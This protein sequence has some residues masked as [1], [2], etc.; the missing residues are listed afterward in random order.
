[1]GNRKDAQKKK[2]KAEQ[3]RRQAERLRRPDMV[4]VPPPAEASFLE[5]RPQPAEGEPAE[6]VAIFDAKVRGTLPADLQT[7]A[8]LVC[9]AL[10]LVAEGHLQI[11]VDR[12]TCIGR[13]SPFSEWRLFVRGLGT[14]QQGDLARARDAWSRLDPGRRPARIAQVLGDAWQDVHQAST[15]ASPAAT[16]AAVPDPATAARG[17]LGRASIWDAAQQIVTMGRRNSSTSFSASQVA[18]TIRRV[19]QV[20][21]LDPDFAAAFAAACRQLA[22]LQ[23]DHE[24]FT[25]LARGTGGPADDPQCHRATFLYLLKFVGGAQQTLIACRQHVD[26]QLPSMRFLPKELRQA[27][28]SEMLRQLASQ[29]SGDSGSESLEKVE[30]TARK[31]VE[32]LLEESIERCPA[33]RSAHSARLAVLKSRA[34]EQGSGQRAA[35]KQ[36]R[37]AQI[38]YAERFPEDHEQL[39]TVIE[40][41]IGEQQF[42]RAEPFVQEL[43]RQRTS[44]PGAATLPW[45]FAVLRWGYLARTAAPAAELSPVRDA[46]EQAWPQQ[47]PREWMTLLDAALQTR[48][49]P[50]DAAAFERAVVA[51]G[52]A[53]RPLAVDAMAYEALQTAAAARELR[54]V[55]RERIVGA[56]H[57]AAVDMPLGPLLETA[58]FYCTLERCGL[59]VVT[60]DHPAAVFGKLVCKR[61]TLKETWQLG[62]GASGGSQLP[63]DLAAFWDAFEWLGEH[64]FFGV[65]T[66]KREPK[67]IAQLAD[68]DPR[69]AAEMLAWRARVAPETLLTPRSKKRARLLEYSL[70]VEEIENLS[71]RMGRLFVEVSMARD[72]AERHQQEQQ[73]RCRRPPAGEGF[74]SELDLERFDLSNMPPIMQL[75]VKWGGKAALA[76]VITIITGGDGVSETAEL[77]NLAKRMGIP[78][79]EFATAMMNTRVWGEQQDEL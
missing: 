52:G 17:L 12:L 2:R 18:A 38:V 70:P 79:L 8:G 40:A 75:F 67:A 53:E 72:K 45:S 36:L 78:P 4:R 47:V 26:K 24:Q 66:P 31:Q 41:L 27:L 71:S 76:E 32:R 74:V 77:M 19:K 57:A 48:T 62:G 1:M 20:R 3:A 29:I 56:A 28:S 10:D 39:I 13:A 14:F 59:D 23:P 63:T 58:A 21:S 11:A 64:D 15:V 60:K 43:V 37:E 46:V 68:A 9:E 42:R 7:Q 33:N 50:P 61:L 55:F 54:Q 30:G 69:A 34:R 25:S 51:V 5:I 65:V 44:Y 49:A 73:R 16:G 22:S 35:E 6:D